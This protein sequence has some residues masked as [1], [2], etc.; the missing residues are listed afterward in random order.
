M[1]QVSAV[2]TASLMLDIFWIRLALSGLTRNMLIVS[3]I[4]MEKKEKER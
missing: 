2:S 4:I 1:L 3:D